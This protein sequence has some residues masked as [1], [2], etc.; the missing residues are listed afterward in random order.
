MKTEQ[1]KSK[2]TVKNGNNKLEVINSCTQKNHELSIHT[3]TCL[4]KVNDNAPT[5]ASVVAKTIKKPPDVMNDDKN[6]EAENNRAEHKTCITVSDTSIDD[7][8]N[9]DISWNTVGKNRKSKTH[10]VKPSVV[11][12]NET[13]TYCDNATNF[14][15]KGK[16][17]EIKNNAKE[18]RK[19]KAVIATPCKV[20]PSRD[21][22]RNGPKKLMAPTKKQQN[23]TN[24]VFS[25]PLN[26][27]VNR[28][29]YG[30]T[31]GPKP[32]KEDILEFEKSHKEYISHN[33]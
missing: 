26:Q 13:S 5:K 8:T 4:A 32:T 1:T 19:S 29:G 15:Q 9:N 23:P 27:A 22:S 10:T 3:T 24:Q 16:D 31:I 21:E 17:E 28:N 11:R 25:K 33:A 20:D 14:D 7:N 18:N 6:R 2:E 30:S 12:S